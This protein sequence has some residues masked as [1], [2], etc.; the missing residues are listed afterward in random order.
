MR[1][2]RKHRKDLRL[3]HSTTEAIT[4]MTLNPIG[5]RA[6][7]VW[8]TQEAA[9]GYRNKKARGKL[10]SEPLKFSFKLHRL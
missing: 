7:G 10:N 6:A 8:R 1:M 4:L 3:E 2:L 5:P 9:G